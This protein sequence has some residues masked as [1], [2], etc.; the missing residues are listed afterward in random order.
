MPYP[1]LPTQLIEVYGSPTSYTATPQTQRINGGVE[2]N[3]V[4]G[5]INLISS[6]KT[7][8]FW[9]KNSDY[10]AI[11]TFIDGLKG[12]PFSYQGIAY[13]IKDGSENWTLNSLNL[14][15]LN[16]GVKRVF[17]PG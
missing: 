17:N 4:A 1:A 8:R 15:E 5:E 13:R 16:L 10:A 6:E 9:V 12:K 7:L 14:W 2:Q 3:S 11:Y